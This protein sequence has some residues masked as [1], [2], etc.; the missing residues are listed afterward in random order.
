MRTVLLQRNLMRGADGDWRKRPKQRFVGC[1]ALIPPF[2]IATRAPCSMPAKNSS[3]S[4]RTVPMEQSQLAE[5]A[6]SRKLFKK[7]HPLLKTRTHSVQRVHPS[8]GWALRSYG[9]IREDLLPDQRPGRNGMGLCQ[10]H[11]VTC[12]TFDLTGTDAHRR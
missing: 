8:E 9:K 3:A 1:L 4:K 7:R 10:P 6:P 5:I 12:Q 11:D 2:L